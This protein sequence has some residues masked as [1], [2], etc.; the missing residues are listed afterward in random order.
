M[1]I[2]TNAIRIVFVDRRT[3]EHRHTPGLSPVHATGTYGKKF[4]Q[5]VQLIE[6]GRK[7]EMSSHRNDEKKQTATHFE[8]HDKLHTLL[9]HPYCGHETFI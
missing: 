9:L 7:Q 8:S 5:A 1:K 3:E 2:E 4:T 6:S